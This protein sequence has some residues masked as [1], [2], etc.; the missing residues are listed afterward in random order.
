MA[1]TG[2]LRKVKSWRMIRYQG[3]P[4]AVRETYECG[5]RDDYTM[6]YAPR[7]SRKCVQCLRP[8]AQPGV[9]RGFYV[10]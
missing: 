4:D 10:R 8:T 7:V 1:S 5:H 3:M 6:P 9:Y 2:P